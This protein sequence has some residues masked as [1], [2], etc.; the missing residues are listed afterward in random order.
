[1]MSAVTRSRG[2]DL[3]GFS[4]SFL[5]A[6]TKQRHRTKPLMHTLQR[7]VRP[8]ALADRFRGK[9]AVVLKDALAQ[10]L[11]PVASMRLSKPL[12]PLPQAAAAP[13]APAASA[14]QS[15]SG[16]ASGLARQSRGTVST[17]SISGSSL[18]LLRDCNCNCVFRCL[19]NLQNCSIDVWFV[20]PLVLPAQYSASVRQLQSSVW[21]AQ[22]VL[23]FVLVIDTM[24]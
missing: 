8:I 7:L 12:P 18:L 1:M 23:P 21:P 19:M 9:S 20:L 16:L 17:L 5:I 24:Q 22:A 10:L 15:Q 2:R 14:A 11:R 3:S 13:A 6:M 4:T